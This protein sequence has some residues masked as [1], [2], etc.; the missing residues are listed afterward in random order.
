MAKLKLI[1]FVSG[2]AIAGGFPVSAQN[3]AVPPVENTV[4]K[5]PEA[6]KEAWDDIAEPVS[7]VWREE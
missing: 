1:V 2:L 7:T 6:V 5:E 3:A 4:Q